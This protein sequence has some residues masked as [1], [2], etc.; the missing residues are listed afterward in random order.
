MISKIPKL[1]DQLSLD[2]KIM[3]F[4]IICQEHFI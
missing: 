4:E 1:K 2:K 3:N